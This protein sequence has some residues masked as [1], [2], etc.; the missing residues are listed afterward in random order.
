MVEIWHPELVEKSWRVLNRLRSFADF[1]LIGGWGVFLWARRAKSRDIDMCIDRDNF[2]A[3]QRRCAEV[4][5]VVKRNPRLRKFEAVPDGVEVG[6]YTPFMCNLVIPCQD[7]MAGG[8]TSKVEGFRVAV[9]EVLLLLKAQAARERWGSEKGL[10]DRVDIISLLAF[11]DVKFDLLEGL[12][13]KYDRDMELIGTLVRVLRE[14]RRE[15]RFLGLSYERDGSRILRTLKRRLGR[16]LFL[17]QT[18]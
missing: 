2:Y 15:Y 18:R 11:V 10:K 17:S 14:S 13:R 5:V 1:V 3:L 8:M 12:V 9:P 6:I 4:G 16:D 7:I